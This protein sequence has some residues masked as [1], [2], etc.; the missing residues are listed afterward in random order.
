DGQPEY[1]ILPGETD[2]YEYPNNQDAA[3]VWYH[4][5]ALGITRL[6]VYAGMA[7]FYLIADEE[8]TL[9]P[10]NAFGFPSGQYEIGMAIQDRTFNEDGS[11]FYNAQLEDAFKGELALVN[12]KVMPFLNVDQGKYRFRMLNGSQS[13]EY[14]LR[15]ENTTDPGNDPNFILVG[16]DLG[17]IDAPI[18]L[19]ND[20]GLQGPAER[21]DVVV[22]FEGYPVGTE[23][24]LRNDDPTLPLL[25][26]IMKFIVTG[27]PGYTGT[28]SSTLRPVD[29]LPES[30][31]DVTRYF[32][33]FK[34]AGAACKDGSG[35]LV[36]EWLIQSLD[37]PNGNVTGKH[38][39]DVTE[40]PILGNREVWEFANPTNSYHPMHIHLVRFQI[41]S[42]TDLNTGQPIPLQPWEAN[43]WKDIVHI[44]AN[45]T[46]RVIMD[47]E[48][49]AGRFPNHCHLLDHED[50][51]M[52]RQFQ[53]SYDP[54]YCDNDGTCD[55]G[56][57][58]QSCPNDCA[59]VSGASCGNGLCEGGDS[60]NFSTCPADCAGKQSG[61]A[62]KQFSCGFDDGQVTNPIGCGVDANDDRCIDSGANLFC[63]ITPRV[64]A[65]C[66]DKLCEGAET[67][68]SCA[69]DC[70]PNVCTVTEQGEEYSCLDGQDNDCDGLIDVADS[71]CLDTDGDGLT[72]AYEINILGTDPNDEDT[73][74]DGLVDGNSVVVL[75]IDYSQ[76]VDADED[77]YVDG[78][79]TLGTVATLPDSDGDLLNDGLE[80]ANGSNPLDPLSYPHIADGDVAPYGAPNGQINAGDLTVMIRLALGLEDTRA[81][82]L[83]HGDLGTPDSVINAADVILLIQMLHSQ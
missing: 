33:L 44:P 50:H 20:I 75:L 78:E 14:H 26:S 61:S 25:P 47:F 71:D 1:H 18:D 82:E 54:E 77:G 76:G 37:G 32:R 59:Q 52:M 66:G 5:H 55:P 4:D 21:M 68:T 8:D 45:T 46:A 81:L 63:R 38:W 49:Y 64:S 27:N 42:K 51:E 43:T 24:I 16:T 31:A 22:D 60:E 58:C 69:N 30:S 35:R 83:A 74:D 79:Q 40:F 6:N 17:L 56:E 36:N 72:N 48:D 28:I 7:G 15:L 10:D 39:D 23:I 13:R 2:I 12:G 29:P 65:C 34:E 53:A 57:D 3:T 67:E 41:V 9:G 70:D 73:D 62:S 11:L 80:V 19:G